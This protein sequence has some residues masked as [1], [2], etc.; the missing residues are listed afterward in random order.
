MPHNV[1]NVGVRALEKENDKLKVSVKNKEFEELQTVNEE[2]LA[3]NKELR[4]LNDDLDNLIS[5]T[6]IATLFLDVDL[7][8]HRY[9]PQIIEV[10]NLTPSDIGHPLYHI[11][12]KIMLQN[13]DLVVNSKQV[14]NER[15]PIEKDVRTE[16]DKWYTMKIS[17]YRTSDNMIEG[18]VITFVD[19]T[20]RKLAEEK[21]K[22]SEEVAKFAYRRSEFYRSLFTHDISNILQVI[23]ST[24]N[25][26]EYQAKDFEEKD[27]LN[28]FFNRIQEQ[29]TKARILINDIQRISKLEHKI[30]D[31]IPID[32]VELLNRSINTLKSS[33]PDVKF[34][35]EFN[36][37][38][39][40]VMLMGTKVLEDC[41]QNILNNA[42]MYNNSKIKKIKIKISEFKKQN[43][44]FIRLTFD[45]NGTGIKG[46]IKEN[47][48]NSFPNNLIQNSRGLGIGLSLVKKTLDLINGEFWIEDR[49]KGDYTKGTKVVLLIPKLST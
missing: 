44:E 12:T 6:Q 8:I 32:L 30:I 10:L 28:E 7:N 1:N 42:I 16:N 5:S 2:L 17:P 34:T 35:V 19:I 38:Y 23:L 49:I 9:T 11:T 21:S 22:N 18:V 48:I 24:V 39:E 36:P 25:L 37:T 47:L 33:Y 13:K 45:D 3:K 4:R 46:Q 20:K 40:K 41:F 27:E 29:I 26:I 15:V 31:I 43:K 14:L